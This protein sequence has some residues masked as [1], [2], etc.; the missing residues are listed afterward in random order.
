MSWPLTFPPRDSFDPADR[1]ALQ[2]YDSV[3]QRAQRMGHTIETGYSYYGRL[4]WS[5]VLGNL[6]SELGRTVRRLGDRGDS[7]THADREFVD[8]VLAV[9]LQTNVVQKRHVPDALSTGVRLEAIEA[10]RERRE[11]DLS[12][13]E[14]ELADFIRSVI[15]GKM[16]AKS[17]DR[18]ESRMGKR[19]A[20]D[21]T[22]FILYLQLTMR[23]HQAVGMP[24]FPEAELTRMLAEF[25]AGTRPIPDFRIGIN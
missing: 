25:K 19:G 2:A 6:L 1:E 3:V 17:W 7:Y 4:L 24:E 18:I 20:V 21:Y 10:L 16:D 15:S 5:P 22:I 14:R 9:D 8:Q 11:T 13:S 23:L 12:T